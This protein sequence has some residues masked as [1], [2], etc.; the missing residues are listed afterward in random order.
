[1]FSLPSLINTLSI[2]PKGKRKDKKHNRSSSDSS[3][4]VITPPPT[5]SPPPLSSS[6]STPRSLP[7]DTTQA[8]QSTSTTPLPS[9]S[10]PPP[11][12]AS[13]KKKTAPPPKSKKLPALT[14]DEVWKVWFER[15]E[16]PE[17]KGCITGEGVESF[18]EDMRVEM[19]GVSPYPFFLR[20]KIMRSCCF[21]RLWKG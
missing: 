17:E 6:V 10:S 13:S 5:P 2:K 21:W 18:F 20:R 9:L 15:Y 19:D 3:S 11:V 16:D 1:M 12:V 7:P 8:P 4:Q 14:F